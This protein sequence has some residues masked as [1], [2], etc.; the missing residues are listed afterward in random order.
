MSGLV[1]AAPVALPY[2][3]QPLPWWARLALEPAIT[4][5]L[6]G[7][8]A[9]PLGLYYLPKAARSVFRPEE[10]TEDYVERSRAALILRRGPALANIQDLVGLPAALKEQAPRYATLRLPTT[11]VAGN[12][13]SVVTTDLQAV[14]LAGAIP[15]AKLVQLPGVGHMLHITAPGAIVNEI[16]AMQA[17]LAE[18]VSR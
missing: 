1:L 15:D 9:V 17:R 8:I 4:R 7:T 18:P 6:A 5:L 13:D 12:A 16:E 2:P 14:P 3:E 11:I 10:M